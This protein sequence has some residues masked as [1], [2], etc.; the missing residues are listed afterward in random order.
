MT[1]EIDDVT[2]EEDLIPDIE[3]P[4]PKNTYTYYT[5][6]MDTKKT[7]REKCAEG[8]KLLSLAYKIAKEQHA[9]ASQKAD[10][11][12][13]EFIRPSREAYLKAQELMGKVI[14]TPLNKE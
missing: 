8:N 14:N 12:Y 10:D 9:T 11:D 3:L 6:L 5:N 4:D 13:R 2:I 7:Y 1:E